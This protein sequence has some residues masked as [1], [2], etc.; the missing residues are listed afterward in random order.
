[1]GATRMTETYETPMTAWKRL[2]WTMIDDTKT[3]V[4]RC[5]GPAD[6]PLGMMRVSVPP[7]L[8]PKRQP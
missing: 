8:T 5:H 3:R 6:A 1:M 4:H 2:R 7:H